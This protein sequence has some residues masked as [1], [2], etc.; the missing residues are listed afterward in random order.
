[1]TSESGPVAGVRLKKALKEF[2]LIVMGVLVALWVEGWRE[3][4]E[5]RQSEQRYLA[6]LATDLRADLAEMDSATVWSRR[7]LQSSKVVLAFLEG[8]DVQPDSLIQAV[9]VAGWQYPPTF[10]THTIDDLRSTGNLR[11][12]RDDSLKRAISSYYQTLRRFERLRQPLIDR[13]WSKYDARVGEILSPRQR[14]TANETFYGPHPGGE[15]I[16]WP[17][18]R[19]EE[20][21]TTFQNR[22]E[23]REA[24]NDAIFAAVEQQAYVNEIRAAAKRMLEAVESSNPPR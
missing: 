13:V 21:R 1:M 10:S 9:T 18:A 16:P 14:L 2:V 24:L 11:L 19:P 6:G 4:R 8:A 3:S 23:L 17:D 15:D 12:L 7:F 22:P 20:I 5:D